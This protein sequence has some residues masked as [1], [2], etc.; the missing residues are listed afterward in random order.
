[1]S[2]K[3]KGIYST[4]RNKMH[5]NFKTSYSRDE[6]LSLLDVFRL[7]QF[8]FLFLVYYVLRL[9]RLHKKKMHAKVSCFTEGYR[10][11]DIITQSLICVANL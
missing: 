11:L 5:K 6:K 3:D 2:N 1:M 7:V 9:L 8:L 4:A 10:H